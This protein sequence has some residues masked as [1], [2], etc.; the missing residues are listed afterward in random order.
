MTTRRLRLAWRGAATHAERWSARIEALGY[1]LV[2]F[3]AALLAA[4]QDA[5]RPAL[6]RA[7]AVA[8]FAAGNV[9]LISIGIWAGDRPDAGRMGPATR[10]LLHWV[11]ALI[12]MPAIAYAG[13]PFF[14]S[15]AAALRHG[16]HQ[17]GRADQPRR[18][19]GHRHEPGR[20]PSPAARTPISTPRSRWCSSC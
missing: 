18:A 8:G 2:P 15:A 4:A 13:R 7:L 17:H 12:A 5:H 10:A 14:A 19:A 3:D 20:R 11:S 6:L 1:R 9:M 16:A